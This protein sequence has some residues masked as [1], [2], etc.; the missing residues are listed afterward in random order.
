MVLVESTLPSHQR[1]SNLLL[2]FLLHSSSPSEI[3]WINHQ[4]HQTIR[5]GLTGA[6][7]VGKSTFIEQFGLYLLNQGKRVAVL[8]GRAI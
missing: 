4:Q 3:S 7:G 8:V 5:I 1:Q 2:T 6:P